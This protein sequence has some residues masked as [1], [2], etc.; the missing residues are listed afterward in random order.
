MLINYRYPALVWG[1]VGS[2]KIVR[3]IM[4]AMHGRTEIED[5][6]FAD[7]PLAAT[8]YMY[9][10]KVEYRYYR[11]RL[12][13]RSAEVGSDEYRS[14]LETHMASKIADVCRRPVGKD[15]QPWPN[16]ATACLRN[17]VLARDNF[18]TVRGDYT[19]ITGGEWSA[20]ASL[21]ALSSYD[22]TNVEHWASV[23]S[24]YVGDLIVID[25]DLWIPVEEPILAVVNRA[26]P[27][28][29]FVDASIYNGRYESPKDQP[30]PF[31]RRSGFTSHYW[32]PEIRFYSILELDA[33]LEGQTGAQ[34]SDEN[35]QWLRKPDIFIPSAF[36]RDYPEKELD[37]AARVVVAEVHDFCK[38]AYGVKTI[39]GGR[40]P[41]VLRNILGDVRR[42]LENEE[43]GDA[44]GDVLLGKLGRIKT[45]MMGMLSES[46]HL[47]G[48]D[49]ILS[50]I[51]DTE[52]MWGNREI[53]LDVSWQQTKNLCP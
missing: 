9:Y 21:S 37:R 36:A 25:G 15:I 42:L 51:K 48:A 40:T 33:L 53:S 23:A 29:N 8:I 52:T 45:W 44:R 19:M 26:A 30:P 3:P 39:H 46:P 50:L 4:V 12:Y 28:A 16:E 13:R 1:Q 7:A 35:L 17:V 11:E 41:A 6:K 10:G 34:I 38:E 49:A 47:G 2:A 14:G 20:M 27:S 24:D 43:L 5:V 31:G 18:R 32:N 22:P